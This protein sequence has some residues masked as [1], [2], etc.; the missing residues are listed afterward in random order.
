KP[1]KHFLLRIAISL[2][3]FVMWILSFKA[4]R[5]WLWNKAEE[6][7]KEKII[8]AKAKVVDEKKGF[9]K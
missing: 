4:V 3:S 7:G 9:L 6:K 5:T 2:G 1:K 8:D